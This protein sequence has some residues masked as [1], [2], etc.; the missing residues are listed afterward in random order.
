M[1]RA[2]QEQDLE[3]VLAVWYSA[4]QVAHPFL[5]E[6]FFAQERQNIATMY[7]PNAETWVYELDD[8]VVGFVSLIGNEVGGLF[9]DAEHQRQGIGHSL[10]DKARSIRD[11]LM[12]DVFKDNLVGR[13][14]YEK[15]GFVQVGEHLHEATGH[16]QLRL[17]LTNPRLLS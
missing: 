9:V 8:I 6:D 4:S 5:D 14:F 13:R 1:I 11:D 3:S 10:M 12:L 7:I 17:Q 2:Y 16:L 15:Y